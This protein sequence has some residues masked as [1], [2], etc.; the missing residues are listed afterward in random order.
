MQSS[1]R[2][3]MQLCPLDDHPPTSIPSWWSSFAKPCSYVKMEEETP[4][5]EPW[6]LPAAC[7][8]IS[9]SVEVLIGSLESKAKFEG[10]S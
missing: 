9:K 7:R 8:G 2:D 5:D 10:M 6:P 4:V 3:E 1:Q